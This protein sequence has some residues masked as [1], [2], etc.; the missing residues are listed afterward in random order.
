MTATAP[1]AASAPLPTAAAEAPRARFAM[2]AF[3]W[4][5]SMKLSV[6]LLLILAA[7]TWLGTLAQID[8]GLWKV[9]R[10]YFESWGLLAELPLSWWGHPLFVL[11]IPLPGAYPVMGLLFVNLLVGG[12][13]RMRWQVRNAGILIVHVGIALLLL[14]GFVKLEYSYSGHLALYEAPEQGQGVGARVTEGS[15]FTSFHDYELALLRDDGDTISERVVPETQLAGARTGTVTVTA[16]GLP[17]TVRVHHWLDNCRPLPKGPMV[18]TASP[19]L[20][21]GD[22]GPSVFLQPEPVDKKREANAAGCYV[23]VFEGDKR[24]AEGI[25]Y[26]EEM[27]PL[28]GRRFPLV[29]EV[30]G[31]RYGLDLRRVV[32]DLPF[33]VRLDRFVKRDHP[34]TTNAADFRSFVTV[35]DAGQELPVQIYMNT[36]LRKDGFVLYQTSYG[37]PVGGPPF[38]SVFEVADNPSDIWP[39]VAC[40]VIAVGMLV[41]FVMKLWRFLHSSTREALAS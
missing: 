31:K 23:G 12:L 37:P 13:W 3:G 6:W 18:R 5:G 20:D 1:K 28:D 21:L 17:F 35:K 33:T 38:F 19:V 8:Q 25:L 15:L 36:P 14:A 34:G 4:L 32:Y 22:G 30:Q 11:K 16:A 9:Q 27:R 26:G 39:A 29:F 24:I 7:L 10:D 40:A 2:T 41:H